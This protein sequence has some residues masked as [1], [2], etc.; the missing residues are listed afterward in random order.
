HAAEA[1]CQLVQSMSAAD[2]FLP[3]CERQRALMFLASWLRRLPVRRLLHHPRLAILGLLAARLI[4]PELVIMGGLTEGSWPAQ[5]DPGP[6]INRPMRE[7]LGL[8]PPESSIGLTAHDFAPGFR[9]P[10]LLL[11]WSRRVK[12]QPAVAS[13]WV[14]RLKMILT[15]ANLP[16]AAGGAGQRARAAGGGEHHAAAARD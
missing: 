12:D 5:P 4:S 8:T 2:P 10:G 9:D 13:R 14:L 3:N 6:W 15:A 1:L 7:T 11:A 16:D